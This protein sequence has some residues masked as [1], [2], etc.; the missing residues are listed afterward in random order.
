MSPV[1]NNPCIAIETSCRQGSV[2]LAQGDNLLDHQRF[3]AVGRHATQLISRLRDLLEAHD[4]RPEDL[5]EVHVSAG[6]G[7]F[8]GIR[9]GVTCARTLLQAVP[10]LR[11]VAVPTPQVV[12]VRAES[13][14]WDRLAVILDAKEDRVHATRFER[15]Q[16]QA[17]PV[18][19]AGV[20]PVETFLREAPR[21]ILLTGEGLGYHE[22]VGEG[23]AH[24]PPEVRLPDAAST[25]R[26]GR[27]LAEAGRYT[28]RARLLP[29]YA[30]QPE[31]VR[32][33][34]ARRGPR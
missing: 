31:A 23:I 7:S 27:R 32:L 5:Q 25:L 6:P 13:L 28:D 29:V 19:E 3:D 1:D 11:A 9:V 4:L 16:G 15:R 18:G 17:E 24:A 26:A 12:A 14:A 34:E 2:A 10:S 21:P 8:T 20:V 33:W 22:L 30:R